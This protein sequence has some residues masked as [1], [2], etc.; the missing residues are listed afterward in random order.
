MFKHHIVVP[1]LMMIW[2]MNLM[3]ILIL[4]MIEVVMFPSTP[5]CDRYLNQPRKE[6]Y[7]LQQ[8]DLI[9]I[10]EELNNKWSNYGE[11]ASID[12]SCAYKLYG[13]DV[14]NQ[15]DV[16]NIKAMEF[17]LKLQ[18]R[19]LKWAIEMPK[20]DD[21]EDAEGYDVLIRICNKTLYSIEK[22][23]G[24]IQF[25]NQMKQSSSSSLE[26]N[27]TFNVDEEEPNDWQSLILQILQ[28]AHDHE[29]SKISNSIF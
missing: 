2:K 28:I 17:S 25:S 9:D 13:F 15:Y 3:M 8:E 19:K 21:P 26:V 12:M 10:C 11:M 20:K 5:K 6:L 23:C 1:E 29:Y 27:D 7:E 18:I 22:C 16:K 24:I 4:Q 14:N